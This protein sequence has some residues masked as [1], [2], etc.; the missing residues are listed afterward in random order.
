MTSTSTTTTLL[1]VL[2]SACAAKVA[3]SPGGQPAAA[4][5]RAR[6][7]RMVRDQE[8][9]G[10]QYIAIQAD[11]IAL[12][13]HVGVADAATGQPMEASTVQMAYSITKVVTAIAVM[14]LVDAGRIDLDAPLSRYYAAH[15]YGPAVTIRSLLAHTSGAPNPMPLDWFVV[16]NEPLDRDAALRSIMA[17]H[18]ARN[19]EPGAGYAYSNIGYWLLEKA[20]E[21]AAGEDYALYVER[22]VFAPLGVGSEAATFDVPPARASA[23][24]HSRRYAPM[25]LLLWALTPSRYWARPHGQWSRAARVQPLGRGYGGLYTSASAL[26]E[27]LRDLLR[28]TPALL[29]AG[30]R[31]RLLAEQHTRDGASTGATLGWVIGE[32]DG[33]RYLGKQGGGLGF[34]GNVRMYPALG[35]ATVLLANRTEISSG[36]IDARSDAL[37]APFVGALNR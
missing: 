8:L 29:S 11:R 7:A 34:H 27:I 4:Q 20:I 31:D 6:L 18:A 13:A 16:E 28:P 35:L 10:A 19:A 30:A 22:R 1:G 9:P 21:A 3:A 5:V 15:P 33:V 26:A 23:T 32:L 36:P 12:D 17:E 37:D 25:N 2:L 24:G 14:Q